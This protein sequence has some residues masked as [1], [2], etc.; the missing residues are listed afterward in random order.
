MDN[1]VKKIGLSALKAL[2]HIVTLII[3][4]YLADRIAGMLSIEGEFVTPTIYAAI[5]FGYF[6]ALPY[7]FKLK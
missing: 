5:T 2:G 4:Y 6:S 1:E 3:L 7:I